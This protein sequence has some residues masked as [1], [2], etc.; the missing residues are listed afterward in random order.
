MPG[1]APSA[2]DRRA[3]DDPR[4]ARF[5]PYLAPSRGE[6]PGRWVSAEEAVAA[7]PDGARVFVAGSAGTPMALMEALDA[8][9]SRFRRL[10]LV[11]AYLMAR[12]AVFQHAGDPFRFVTTQASLAWKHLWASG[13]VGILPT[14][15][16]DHRGLYCAGGPLAVDVAVIQVS[17]PGPEGRV[18]LGVS[19]GGSIDA[20]RAAPLVIAQVNESMPYTFGA[21]ELELTEIDLLVEHR[22][23]VLTARVDDT[24]QDPVARAIARR[25]APFVGDGC[26]LQFGIG[27]IPDAILSDLTDRRGLRVHSGMVSEACVDLLDAGAVDGP[28]IT[29]EMLTTP[30]ML[31][32]VDRNESVLMAPAAYTHGAGVLARLPRFRALNST[33]EVAL[34]GSMNSESSRGRVLSGPGGA[35]DYAMAGSAL[36]GDARSIIGLKSTAAA[37]RVSRVVRRVE[38]PDNVMLP[39]YLAAVV[40]TEH[41]VAE[42]RGLTLAAR[43]EALIAIAHPEH[44]PALST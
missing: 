5:L 16:S 29:A 10:E 42:L 3:A 20:A 38:A 2:A 28:M 36:T 21:G 39:A 33:L 11:F 43:A 26:T 40:V 13:H 35:P 14:R 44:R 31:E 27:A 41:G 12:P 30:R 37:G 1:P 34:D 8:G 19:V 18:S 24:R 22:E 15:Y 4:R 6:R 23:T 17:R 25:A 7:I 9:R 32:W